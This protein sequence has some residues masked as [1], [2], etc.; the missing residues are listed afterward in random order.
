MTS[1]SGGQEHDEA[2]VVPVPKD[3]RCQPIDP[4]E[5]AGKLADLALG[6]PSGRVPDI[7]GPEVSSLAELIRL[8]VAKHKGAV[9]QVWMPKMEE[10]RAGC[11]LVSGNSGSS[12][13]P[14]G[15]TTWEQFLQQHLQ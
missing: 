15:K 11:L 9:V 14:Y 4:A 13:V 6:P 5:V 10:I 8:R 7:G 12:S 2:P 1:S 3:F